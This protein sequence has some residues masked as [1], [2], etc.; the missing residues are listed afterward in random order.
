M[1]KFLYSI[2]H[3][4]TDC[5]MEDLEPDYTG[6]RYIYVKSVEDN[7]LYLKNTRGDTVMNTNKTWILLDKIIVKS[8][9]NP[10]EF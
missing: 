3:M 9:E 5:P 4:F 7:T 2:L 1:K 10:L 6:H 8:K